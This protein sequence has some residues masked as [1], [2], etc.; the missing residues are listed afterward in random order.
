MS[1]RHWTCWVGLLLGCASTTPAPTPAGAS[2]DGVPPTSRALPAPATATP[3]KLR[4]AVDVEAYQLQLPEAKEGVPH[5][6]DAA[7]NLVCSGTRLWLDGEPLGDAQEVLATGQLRRLVPL[8]DALM[9]KRERWRGEHAGVQL[10]GEVVLWFDRSTPLRVFKSAFQTAAFAGYPNLQLAVRRRGGAAD[11][12]AYQMFDARVPGPPGSAP[13]PDPFTL[14]VD[15]Q[16]DGRIQLAWKALG[17]VE[18]VTSVAETATRDER[19]ALLPSQI[20]QE[21][22]SFGGHTAPED[23]QMDQAILH[24]PND[25]PLTTAVTLLDAIYTPKRDYAAKGQ[26]SRVPAFMATF[27]V[28]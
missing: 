28:N 13:A 7:P 23:R 12:I 25:E 14:H 24:A 15:Y 5:A 22:R 18:R 2:R 3:A 27:S 10:P 26:V 21:W 9:A 6:F 20:D 16:V 11:A 19:L 8:F 17:K 1:T 4:P